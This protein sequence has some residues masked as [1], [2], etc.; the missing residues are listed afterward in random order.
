MNILVLKNVNRHQTHFQ[1]NIIV[2]S[3]LF[4][5]TT[6][7]TS[8]QDIRGDHVITSANVDQMELLADFGNGHIEAATYSP[9]G[10]SVA[11][12]TTTGI[13]FYDIQSGEVIDR[14]AQDSWISALA[15]SPDGLQIAGVTQDGVR[16]W[17]TENNTVLY[18][19][20]HT[21]S[22]EATGGPPIEA[23]AW[24]PDGQ[25]LATSGWDNAIHIW[26]A[27][28]GTRLHIL[29]EHSEWVDALA[30]S[31]DGMKLASGGF[32]NLVHIW[33]PINGILLHKLEGHTFW[34]SYLSWSPDSIRLISASQTESKIWDTTSG[35][36]ISSPDE[37]QN[38]LRSVEWSPSG[39]QIASAIDEDV[40]MWNVNDNTVFQFLP[41]GETVINAIWSP[42][43]V[44]HY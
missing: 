42:R 37:N 15:W 39:E 34:T 2:L 6:L 13:W 27:A 41:H 38:W 1:W 40:K 7:L 3:C 20:T 5:I 25:W 30:W 18:T 24:S 11:V 33:D 21:R 29:R 26:D 10:T 12:A 9:N 14:L 32:D 4:L 31:P 43:W 28:N 22:D 19:L 23:V 44:T 35:T 36:L 17:E 8:A 16:V